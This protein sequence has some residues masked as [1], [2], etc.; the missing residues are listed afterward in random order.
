MRRTCLMLGGLR[1]L[2]CAARRAGLYAE[3]LVGGDSQSLGE[4]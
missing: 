3:Q 2:L 4:A 1:R